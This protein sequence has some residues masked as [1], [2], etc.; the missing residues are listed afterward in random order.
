M[1]WTDEDAARIWGMPL[2]EV[3]YLCENEQIAGAIKKNGRWSMPD[4]L[5]MP[6]SKALEISSTYENLVIANNLSIATGNFIWI[7]RR[8]SKYMNEKATQIFVQETKIMDEDGIDVECE[9]THYIEKEILKL[10]IKSTRNYEDNV[11]YFLHFPSGVKVSRHFAFTRGIEKIRGFVYKCFRKSSGGKTAWLSM[12]NQKSVRFMIRDSDVDED[13]CTLFKGYVQGEAMIKGTQQPII[14]ARG[15]T[16]KIGYALIPNGFRGELK[17]TMTFTKYTGQHFPDLTVSAPNGDG[18]GFSKQFMTQK[19]ACK[20]NGLQSCE[21]SEYTGWNSG[22][23]NR[24]PEIMVFRNPM[25]GR[26]YFDAR[27]QGGD[28]DSEV[29]FTCNQ[30]WRLIYSENTQAFKRPSFITNG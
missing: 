22:N 6:K 1:F 3:T 29:S 23:A 18:F 25:P 17:I 15:E 8:S 19:T 30:P 28:D 21:L 16:K 24:D 12:S 27:N 7:L 20:T 14:V 2:S 13:D 26:W 11:F 10:V 5:P 4:N 9:I